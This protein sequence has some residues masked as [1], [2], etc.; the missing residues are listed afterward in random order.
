MI[1]AGET[2]WKILAVNVADPKADKVHSIEDARREFPGAI[3]DVFEF[4]VCAVVES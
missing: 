2:D 3:E 4:L 1:D